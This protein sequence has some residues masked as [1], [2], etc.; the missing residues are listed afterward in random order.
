MN[1]NY[2]DYTNGDENFTNT[3]TDTLEHLQKVDIRKKNACIPPPPKPGEIMYC[4]ICGKPMLPEDFSQ[5]I[6][7][8]KREFKWHTHDKCMKYIF[9]DYIDRVT[10]GVMAERQQRDRLQK[11][12]EEKD[13]RSL[14]PGYRRR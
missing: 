14:I 7:I 2:K 11:Q 1:Y 3:G 12:Q 5:D 9:E 4:Q 6:K 10:P 8:A 13:N